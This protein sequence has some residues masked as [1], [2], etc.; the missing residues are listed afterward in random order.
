MRVLDPGHR[1]ALTHLDGDG[2]TVLQFVK[3]EGDG[4]P[5]NVGTSEGVTIQ[6]VLRALIDRGK[7][8]QD[9]IPCPE[10]EMAI[11]HMISAVHS[12]EVRAA[13][14]HG[15]TEPTV[16]ESVYGPTC[17]CGHVGCDGTQHKGGTP[18]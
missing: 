2:E 12:L 11:E 4:Y 14:R 8:V 15:R 13:R 10:T 16:H 6:E 3:R 9:Q 5:G 18:P 1:Y 17:S 7:Y